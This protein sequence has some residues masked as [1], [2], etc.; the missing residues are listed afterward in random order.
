MSINKKFD[1]RRFFLITYCVIMIPI[2]HYNTAIYY[3]MF[4]NLNTIDLDLN[5]SDVNGLTKENNFYQSQSYDSHIIFSNVNMDVKCI[6]IVISNLSSETESAIVY[7]DTGKGFIE[8]ESKA[9]TM[10]KGINTL[11]FGEIINIKNLRIYPTSKLGVSFTLDSV[12]LNKNNYTIWSMICLPLFLL[13]LTISLMKTK[14]FLLKL[15][16]DIFIIYIG[17]E[18]FCY[19]DQFSLNVLMLIIITIG[20]LF[21]NN[22]EGAVKDE[23]K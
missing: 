7:Y 9:F 4:A 8:F 18:F 3:S 5:T 10:K 16:I 2:L 23:I 20:I 12:T 14:K 11:D 6:E 15:S 21:I 17:Y 1:V 22:D 19:F 13:L